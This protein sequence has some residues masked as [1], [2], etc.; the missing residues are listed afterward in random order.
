LVSVTFKLKRRIDYFESMD[1]HK[2][3]GTSFLL[4]E[5]RFSSL[6]AIGKGS[7]GV[8]VSALD[9]G[10]MLK[11]AIKKIAPMAK[12]TIDA[13]HILRE[14]R[15]MRYMG[16]HE[17]IITLE[18]LIVDKEHD[19]LYIV[20]ELLDS[21]L[22][23]VIQSKQSLSENHFRHFMMQILCGLKYLHEN[24]II[25]RDLKPGNLLVTREC[26]LRITD[27]GLARERPVGSSHSDPDDDIEEPM[28]EH[29]VTRWYRPP[30]LMLCPDGMY[31]YAVDLWSVGCIFAEMLGRK[32][33]FPG[34]NFVDQLTLIFDVIGSPLASEVSHI[35]N[36]QARKYLDTQNS[37]R[38]LP[39]EKLFPKASQNALALLENL[40]LF[41]PERRLSVDEALA[42][43]YVSE[44]VDE[45]SPSMVFPENDERCEF[46]F[47]RDGSTKHS[48][49]E[50]ICAEA[51]SLKEEKRSP[52]TAGSS[53]DGRHT[54]SSSSS[55]SSS[56]KGTTSR[57]QRGGS[58]QA[59]P[60]LA[61]ARE[62]LSAAAEA[63]SNYQEK[64]P[65]DPTT[66]F[67]SSHARAAR[68]LEDEEAS[69]R[70]MKMMQSPSR[71]RRTSSSATANPRTVG[72]GGGTCRKDAMGAILR[73]PEDSKGLRSRPIAGTTAAVTSRKPPT[74]ARSPKFS[75][76][77][78][79]RPGALETAP[80][81]R[82][83]SS[84]SAAPGGDR[85][86][87]QFGV[88]GQ[89]VAKR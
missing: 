82:S 56:R 36:S 73:A 67:K 57:S 64:P 87:A 17:N 48:L 75:V 43:A 74:V 45:E 25:H 63:S 79:R 89:S 41:D 23:R 58:S 9:E 5:G 42:T 6:K 32:P 12:H 4:P 15:I 38:A 66:I 26:K 33:L 84:A 54:S 62:W 22:H 19:E 28:T 37:K 83:A 55:S 65:V 71:K 69:E 72:V 14:I 47:E 78:R 85:K 2:V 11:V 86:A 77:S 80:S 13:K 59:D 29:V 7:Y 44:A 10:S 40:L 8:V 24:R 61:K 30:E 34:K 31:T 1:H 70:A 21:D 88:R 35:K 60:E 51:Q 49:K 20:M 53:R 68:R 3:G 16:R 76:L 81:T 46:L 50:L 18:D 39:M 52:N 27:F